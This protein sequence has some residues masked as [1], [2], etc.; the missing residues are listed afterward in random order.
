MDH[1]SSPSLGKTFSVAAKKGVSHFFQ[2]L[3]TWLLGLVLHGI[4]LFPLYVGCKQKGPWLY[5]ALAITFLL[6]VLFVLPLGFSKVNYYNQV[7]KGQK[8][9]FL[10]TFFFF[11]FYVLKIKACLFHWLLVLLLVFL[12]VALVL[13]LIK[14]GGEDFTK[15][16][17]PITSL[18]IASIS[19]NMFVM[20]FL[21]SLLLIVFLFAYGFLRNQIYARFF[22][23]K[24]Q[25]A[26][27]ARKKSNALLKGNR[28]KQLFIGLVQFLLMVPFYATVLL[29]IYAYFS[30]HW[31]NIVTAI[32]FLIQSR[33]AFVS[34]PLVPYTTP[35]LFPF[36]CTALG[37][38]AFFTPFR[39]LL[40]S[41]FLRELTHE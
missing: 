22:A 21:F 14:Q 35:W 17:D 25:S 26:L 39:K 40:P 27:S 16:L 18:N 7:A 41:T 11:F 31:P 23:Q 33:L 15:V 4:A 12:F 5:G 37:F 28:G 24:P 10:T 30:E 34:I 6:Y 3:I 1:T 20:I 29:L 19:V 9:H 2:L 13:Y 8:K 32:L 38:T 36:V